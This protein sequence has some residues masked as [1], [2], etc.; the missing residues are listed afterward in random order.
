VANPLVTVVTPTWG[1]NQF[2]MRAV[3]SVAL[4]TYRPIQHI[5]VSDGPN[6]ELES[7]LRCVSK[8]HQDTGYELLVESLPEHGM[9]GR[10]GHT[11]RLL[12]LGLAK[13]KYIAYLDDDDEY[14]SQHVANLARLL[15]DDPEIGFSHACLVMHD[16]GN[17][18]L[19]GS[20]PAAYGRITTSAIMHRKEL[21]DIATWRDDGQQETVDWDLLAR[22][23]E[24]GV[25]SAYCPEISV[26]GYKEAGGSRG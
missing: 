24:A 16:P 4:Q 11:A 2:I 13:G 19:C 20:Y 7:M 5:V 8:E 25:Q 17:A 6:P 1:R 22:W 10:W 23:L 26:H 15:E 21:L 18:W 9:G 14:L 12:G 3:M